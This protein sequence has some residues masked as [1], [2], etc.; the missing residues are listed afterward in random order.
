[1]EKV[2]SPYLLLLMLIRYKVVFE[3]YKYKWNSAYDKMLIDV[4]WCF[5]I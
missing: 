1:M 2:V 4:L 5:A 3:Y